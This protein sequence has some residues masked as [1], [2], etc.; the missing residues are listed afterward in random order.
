MY[1]ST[2][3]VSGKTSKPEVVFKWTFQQE[4]F[5]FIAD[6]KGNVLAAHKKFV[7]YFCT[8]TTTI[9]L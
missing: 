4:A 9:L 5:V 6:L 7:R 2:G 8:A 3:E 1:L